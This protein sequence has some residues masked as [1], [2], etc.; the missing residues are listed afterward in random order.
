MADGRA[1]KLTDEIFQLL[2]E[3]GLKRQ[4]L[5]TY[6]PDETPE[7]DQTSILCV[8]LV[9]HNKTIGWLYAEL[10]GIYGRFILQDQDLVSV[11]A[12]QAAVALENTNWAATLEQKV[13]QRTAELARANTDL[14]QRNSELA[15][16]SSIQEGLAKQLDYQAIVDT[17]GD[18]LHDLF[19]AQVVVIVEFDLEKQETRYPYVFEKGERVF[20][21]DS[22]LTPAQKDLIERKEA[23]LINDHQ[24]YRERI[25]RTYSG[26]Q[27]VS[28]GEPTK[29][30]V[31]V[32]LLVGGEVKGAIGLQNVDRKNAYTQADLRLLSTLANSMSVALEN[33]RLFNESGRLRWNEKR[34]VTT[35]CGSSPSRPP[36]STRDGSDRPTRRPTFGLGRC[37][38]CHQGPPGQPIMATSP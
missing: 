27:T 30:A 28:W 36:T 33:A 37:G 32:P 3:T 9:T 18:Q 25:E 12:N 14:E 34:P 16:I 10:S 31:R 20:L 15:I 6:S 2:D 26:D 13:E 5:L 4:P 29:S 38:Y 11:L 22:P 19:D 23:E 21:P 1:E 8:P 7:L 24:R 17:V 35:S